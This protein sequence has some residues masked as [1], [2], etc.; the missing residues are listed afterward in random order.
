[1]RR[2]GFPSTENEFYVCVA[3]VHATKHSAELQKYV[4]RH[5]GL[6]IKYSTS[7]GLLF[8]LYLILCSNLEV[9]LS[10]SMRPFILAVA[11]A[12]A[13]AKIHTIDWK[14]PTTGNTGAYSQTIAVNDQIKL[15]WSGTHNVAQASTT[16]SHSHALLFLTCSHASLTRTLRPIRMSSTRAARC[17][18]HL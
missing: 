17:Q 7:D 8:I 12:T 2:Y 6:F 1:M 4:S 9:S 14:I 5:C 11:A 10:L 3:C 13:S 16:P 18:A 15:V